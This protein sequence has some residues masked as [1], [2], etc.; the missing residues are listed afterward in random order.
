MGQ[1]LARHDPQP[2]GNHLHEDG[3]QAG[4]ADHPQQPVFELGAGLQVGAPVARVHVA[5]ADQNGRADE[6]AP[7]PPETRLM[8]GN[9]DGAMHALQRKVI[10]AGS[11]SVAGSWNWRV[12]WGLWRVEVLF[13]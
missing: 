13:I 7:L 4:Q 6:G 1:V 2:G 11:T 12:L 5:D 3:H 10:C 9:L 8:V